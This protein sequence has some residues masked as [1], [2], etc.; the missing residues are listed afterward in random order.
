MPIKEIKG[1]DVTINNPKLI[2]KPKEEWEVIY[3]GK[4]RNLG[5]ATK[6][7]DEVLKEYGMHLS[8]YVLRKI[9]SDTYPSPNSKLCRCLDIKKVTLRINVKIEEEM[10]E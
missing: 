9:V 2:N 3:T 5:D 1:W 7:I 8:Y 4:F 10:I 6:K